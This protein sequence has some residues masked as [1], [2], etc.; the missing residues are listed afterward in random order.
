M[1]GHAFA[2]FVMLHAH[3]AG[4]PNLQFG[5]VAAVRREMHQCLLKGEAVKSLVTKSKLQALCSH[6]C[7]PKTPPTLC[8]QH[9]TSLHCVQHRVSAL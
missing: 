5:L 9:S 1:G 7:P 3:A 2:A 4:E 8:L 6:Q